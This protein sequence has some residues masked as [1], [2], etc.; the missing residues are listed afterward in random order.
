MTD[1]PSAPSAPSGPPTLKPRIAASLAHI[2]QAWGMDWKSVIMVPELH[3]KKWHVCAAHRAPELGCNACRI[4]PEEDVSQWSSTLVEGLSWLARESKESAIVAR[5]LLLVVVR[6]KLAREGKAAG[7]RE[8]Q[9]ATRD[10]VGYQ[11]EDRRREGTG[12]WDSKI[13]MT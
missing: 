8:S 5:E 1:S 11:D 7:C 6:E 9:L 13:P 3:P 2:E 12:V 10:A 4:I